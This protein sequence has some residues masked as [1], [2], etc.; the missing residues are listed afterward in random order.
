VISF[1]QGFQKSNEF[2]FFDLF[3][4][5]HLFARGN[6]SFIDTAVS[7]HKEVIQFDKGRLVVHSFDYAHHTFKNVPESKCPQT[8]NLTAFMTN[9]SVKL[10]QLGLILR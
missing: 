7:V 4:F 1:F 6:F 2:K 3:D 8:I 9:K 5:N 10:G